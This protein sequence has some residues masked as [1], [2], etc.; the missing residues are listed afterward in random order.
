MRSPSWLVAALVAFLVFGLGPAVF[1]V[2]DAV[3]FDANGFGS[4][5][6]TLWL[7]RAALFALG[8]AIGA[9]LVIG[10]ARYALA[11]SPD[12]KPQAQ[13]P[14]VVNLHRPNPSDQNPLAGLAERLPLT[15]VIHLGGLLLGTLAGLAAAGS[16]QDVLLAWQSP[17]MGY[18]EPIFGNDASFYVFLLPLLLTL[19]GLLVT[20][21][22]ISAFA[23][24]AVYLARSAV[25]I[26]F[27]QVDG[28]L[29][30][31]G[32]E[33]LPAARNHIGALGATVLLLMSLGAWLQRYTLLYA[34]D[35]LF[36]GPGYADLA[37]ALPLLAVHAIVTAM[38]SCVL[39]FG[40][41]RP[42]VPAVLGAGGMV[43]ASSAIGNVYPGVLQRFSVDPNELTREGP[44]IVDHIRAT[45]WAFDLDRIEEDAL[46]GDA[47]LTRDDIAA[48]QLT[49]QNVR[50]WDHQPLL[51]TF[52]QVQE[53]RTYYEFAR[54]DNDRYLIGGDLRQVM[55]SP[56]ELPVRALPAQ[57]RTWVNE[58]MTY[59]H[60]YGLTLGPVNE[61]TPQGLPTL[62]V[63]DLPPQVEF[64]DDLRIDRPEIYFG[65]TMDKPVLVD[66]ENP[67][68]DFPTGDDNAY[69][70]Y[71]GKGGVLLGNALWRALWSYRLGWTDLLFSSDLRA[72][73]RILL[74][75][76]V[77]ERVEKVAPF[78][79]YD[80]DAYMV[81]NH[82]RLVWVLDAYTTTD[83]IP[84]SVRIRGIGNY[85]RN[86]IKVT[87]DAYDGT[88]TFYLMD[89][90]EPLAKAWSRALP[91]LFVPGEQMPESLRA[92]LRT[93]IDHFTVQSSLFATY[94]M[95]EPQIFYNRE[96]EWEV[97]SV[98]DRR[99]SPYFTI[100]KLPGGDSEEFIL[101]L[102][103][104][105]K[106]KNNLAAW[107]VARND[108]DRLG[109]LRVYKFP[110][111]KMV[112]GPNMIMARINQDDAISEKMS[113]WNQ[114]GSTVELGTM[115][116]IP[117]EA[118]LIYVQPL[119][120]RAESG[121]IP[122]LKRVIVAYEDQIAMAS[123]L[124]EGLQR[125]FGARA[126]DLA[127]RAPD[128]ARPA[129]AEEAEQVLVPTD[130]SSIQQAAGA[131]RAAQ[132]A[133][134][135]GDWVRFGAA[136]ELL[137]TTLESLE[138]ETPPEP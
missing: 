134:A 33:I 4:V 96:D 75:R 135:E 99:M 102:P 64:P 56:R 69:T 70:T 98:A 11:A 131:W 50:L 54:V 22:V 24:A 130:G 138:A 88:M 68:F 63:K 51:E 89:R 3:W 112:Y 78:L 119:Y 7:T 41:T 49:I 121:S 127:A 10:N 31:R 136:M 95:E 1:L 21:T 74:Y 9:G 122:E 38:A 106:S 115:L 26:D 67:E 58:A 28:Q 59:T 23:S 5:F 129:T 35:G 42:S 125:I 116:V 34:Q 97:P 32:V 100:M 85:M 36:A 8:L 61:V 128:V 37:G 16:W 45:R 39:W 91:D 110:K 86:P 137:G 57:A 113:L 80:S 105:P 43:L 126:P 52:A 71:A 55:L 47:S 29:Q 14:R 82:G 92:H 81:I 101:M 25:R 46:T 76:N 90:E 124:E 111:D 65:E 94:H 53:I 133:A 60:G 73:T 114:Q 107:M 44:Q 72:D 83:R 6:R 66:T 84:Y 87:V 27:V 12:P 18:V 77:R 109:E 19:R 108:G 103:F 48:N 118:S 62:W 20:F 79:Q 2:T 40:V 117:I 15:T 104:T 93:P 123:T 132:Q 17:P 30:A 13:G 120:L